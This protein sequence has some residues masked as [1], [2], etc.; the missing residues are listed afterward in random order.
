[1]SYTLQA[2]APMAP[3]EPYRQPQPTMWTMGY[4][5]MGMPPMSQMAHQP[6]YVTSYL[7]S[8]YTETN[9]QDVPNATFRF[10]YAIRS[11]PTSSASSPPSPT[12]T[13]TESLQPMNLRTG[14]TSRSNK[15]ISRR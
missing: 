15:T 7:Q 5:Q 1:M 2:V 3:A 8:M 10:I 11:T 12:P 6:M 13:P 9:E 14:H 4:P